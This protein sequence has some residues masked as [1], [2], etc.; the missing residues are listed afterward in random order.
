[1][2]IITLFSERLNELIFDKKITSELFA[3]EIG[4]DISNL[5][6]YLRKES[7]PNLY[8]A[9]KIAKFF[10]CSLDFLFGLSEDSSTL[11]NSEIK[12]FAIQFQTLLKKHNSTRYRLKKET[13]LAKQSI[14]DWYHGIRVPTIENLIILAQY[15][16][17]SLD[18]IV[19]RTTS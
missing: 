1:M 6:R 7:I 10:G 5:Y 11:F 14:D 17:C 8:N 16:D 19:G 3:K 4:I 13:S 9:I 15:F 18:Y 12:P 2:D